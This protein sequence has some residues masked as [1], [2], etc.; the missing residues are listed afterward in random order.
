MHRTGAVYGVD[1]GPAA[2]Q[3]VF[4]RG[5]SLQPGEWNNYD[6]E[7]AGDAYTV[8][9][10][11]FETATFTNTTA[12]RG[13]PAGQNASSGFVGVQSHTGQVFVPSDPDQGGL[14]RQGPC[15]RCSVGATRRGTSIRRF[16]SP[17]SRLRVLHLTTEFPP[18]IYGGM[19][20]AV[21][22]WVTSSARSG[23]S[24]AV[25]LVEGPLVLGDQPHV[26]HGAPHDRPQAGLGLV[27]G[28]A[29]VEFLQVQWA[30][31]SQA[32]VELVRAWQPDI[33]HL[34]TAVLWPVAQAIL[35]EVGVPLV[36][37]VHSV[38]RAG[39]EIGEEPNLWLANSR[40]QSDAIL[41]ADRVIALSESERE[42][43]DRYYPQV[44]TRVRVVGNGIDDSVNAQRAVAREHRTGR[45]VILYVGRLVERKGIRDLL[46]AV[47][48]VVEADR[49]VTFVFA[50]GP[51]P[52]TGDE[53]AE[54]WLEEDLAPFRNWITFTGWLPPGEVNRWYEVADILVVPSRY[55]PFGMVILEG[56]LHGLPIVATGLGGPAEIIDS[57]RTGVLVPPRDPP[58]L[59]A[60]LVCLIRDPSRRWGLG[61][62]AAL[63]VR[64][65]WLWPRRVEVMEEV[66]RELLE[67]RELV[68][69]TS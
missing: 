58:A 69:V 17:G 26:V 67:A 30:E 31:G 27:E 57:G 5:S 29:G 6:I 66:Y 14:R 16:R 13:V 40:T 34:H 44:R 55:E 18:L 62:S 28:P 46:A 43:I 47:A 8:R 36:Y 19:G 56:M 1:V 59:A 39:Y 61:R 12:G 32:G 11:G 9:L 4:Y 35:D 41:A 21:G 52:L 53:V 65:R 7:V 63:E 3:R 15:R 50:G 37:H 68:A 51:P 48:T 23:L 33:V 42:L 60:A 49:S 10:N 45:P 25:E 2:E 54:Q 20:T 64:D 22:G 24:V 38:D